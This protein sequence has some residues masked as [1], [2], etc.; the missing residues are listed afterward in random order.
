M[1]ATLVH[2]LDVQETYKI[3]LRGNA[4]DGLEENVYCMIATGPKMDV[5]KDVDVA[6]Y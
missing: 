4:L 2:Q 5:L 3:R 6:I 1:G